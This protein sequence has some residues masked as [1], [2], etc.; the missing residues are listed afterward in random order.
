MFTYLPYTD[1]KMETMS[2]FTDSGNPICLSY[3]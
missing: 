2:Y 3:Y 1:M